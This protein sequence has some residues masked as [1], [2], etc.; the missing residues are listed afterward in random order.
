V[1]L[2]VQSEASAALIVQTVSPV[3]EMEIVHPPF[4]F[5]LTE[6]AHSFTGTMLLSWLRTSVLLRFKPL[7]ERP[8]VFIATACTAIA[9]ERA[10]EFAL[11]NRALRTELKYV[12][13]ATAARIPMIETTVKT[14]TRLK[15]P[16]I[17]NLFLFILRFS[18]ILDA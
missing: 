18:S 15:P 4:T 11:V 13:M 5:C 16:L 6:E 14:S 3:P 10:L 7:Y 1:G 12:G 2:A 8:P 17:D 9:I